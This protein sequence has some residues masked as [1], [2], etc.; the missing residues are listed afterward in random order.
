MKEQIERLL[1]LYPGARASSS[2][3]G[4]HEVQKLFKSLQREVEDLPLVR[5]NPDLQV[6]YSYGK[7]NWAAVPWLAILDTR[8]TSSTQDGTYIVLLFAEDGSGCDLKIGQGV[9][10]LHGALGKKGAD[11][12][13]RELAEEVRRLFPLPDGTKFTSVADGSLGRVNKM[14]A[15]YEA[16]S[17]Y[18]RFSESSAIPPDDDWI[19]DF[20]VLLGVYGAYADY[21]IANAP[22][23]ESYDDFQGRRVWAISAGEGGSQWERFQENGI[24]A[25]GWRQL[26]SLERYKSRDEIT[27]ALA[28]LRPEGVVPSNDSLACFQFC[29]EVSQGDIVIAKQGRK[30]ILG[31]GVVK[32][33]YQYLE[34][35]RYPNLREV[36]WVRTDPT[37]WPGS[38][39]TPKTLTEVDMAAWASTR[40]LIQNY[41]DLD[42]ASSNVSQ[43]DDTPISESYG[44]SN[45]I[46]DGSFL[47][48]S[49]LR[50]LLTTLKRKKN[51]ILQG[52]PGTGKTWLAKR[53]AFA[54]MGRKDYSRMRAV[55]F[56][57]NLSYEDF[58]RGWRPTGAS[59]G[60]LQLAD[61]PFLEVVEDARN[62]AYPHVLVIEEVNRGNPA[63][64]F[65][66]LLT[67]MEADKRSPEDALE[68]SYRK[69][70]GERVHIP[71]NLFVI[72]TMNIADRSLAIV[73]MALR[74]RFAFFDMN[75]LF[76][77]QW[78]SWLL[79]QCGFDGEFIDRVG[80]KIEDLNATIESDPALGPQFRVGHSFLSPSATAD[81][82][83]PN[84]WYEQ[85]VQT[86]LSPLIREYWFDDPERAQELIAA[87][88]L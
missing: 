25:I 42:G 17:I 48:D 55:Q 72:G 49:E 84:S 71:P 7:G 82:S 31:M 37:E 51:L 77:R 86:E 87:L 3:G 10:K 36:D 56:H 24:V 58:V 53:L 15:L 69:F 75:P 47:S 13:L 8:L 73:D 14:A 52:P 46:S 21:A 70:P 35:E 60:R 54:L 19:A 67:L 30:R 23:E 76:N 32:S 39:I 59:D 41:L 27:E 12:K 4:P 57:P 65:G 33:G 85:I 1:E 81:V 18:S 62:S 79:N 16:S 63:Q 66:E 80:R 83:G 29:N 88:A 44:V 74:R 64:I 45:I 20:N 78:K 38:G 68:L 28:Q 26:G 5:N 11:K 43:E 22:A 40:E 9:T 34:G 61:G 50:G 2:F 6:T